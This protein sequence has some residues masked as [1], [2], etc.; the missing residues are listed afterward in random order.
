VFLRIGNVI[1][2]I[3]NDHVGIIELQERSDRL[4]KAPRY[5]GLTV[6]K[7]FVQLRDLRIAIEQI[8]TYE[9]QGEVAIEDRTLNEVRA[10][11][12]DANC[13]CGC[14]KTRARRPWPHQKHREDPRFRSG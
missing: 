7:I 8:G 5:R 4:A 3:P 9:R 11:C 12:R 2:D 1:R 14:W 13:G 6:E 10:N